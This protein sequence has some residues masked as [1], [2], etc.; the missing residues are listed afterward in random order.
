MTD[1]VRGHSGKKEGD[2]TDLADRLPMAETFIG[3]I[4]K[5]DE[6]DQETVRRFHSLIRRDMVL[7]TLDFDGRPFRRIRTINVGTGNKIILW[8]DPKSVWTI[9]EACT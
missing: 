3:G 4:E 7:A 8:L 6:E 5:L 9:T 2:M 1:T